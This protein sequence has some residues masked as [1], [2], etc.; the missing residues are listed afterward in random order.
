MA[1]YRLESDKL[2]CVFTGKMDTVAAMKLENEVDIQVHQA[3]K[4]VVFDLAGVGYISSS[5]IRICMQTVK[6]AGQGNFKIVN[7]TDEVKRIFRVAGLEGFL[8]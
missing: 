2:V 1:E 7:A 3:K 5:F 4:P 6:T 8:G